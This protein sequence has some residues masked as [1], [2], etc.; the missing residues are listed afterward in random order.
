MR[1]VND[2]LDWNVD[3]IKN[4][5]IR[6]GKLRS[7]GNDLKEVEVI[8][9][10]CS[11]GDRTLVN[12]AVKYADLKRGR[13]EVTKSICLWSEEGEFMATTFEVGKRYQIETT[14][15]RSGYWSWVSA[16]EITDAN[17]GH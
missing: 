10:W 4:Q 13:A 7:D 6:G 5:A 3:K 11:Q 14:R 16:K 9:V 12:I 15:L 17:A 2:R 1:N 8:D